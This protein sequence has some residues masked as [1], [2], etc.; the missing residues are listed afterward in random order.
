VVV[1]CGN[2]DTKTK[3][4]PIYINIYKHS[5]LQTEEAK[6]SAAVS[7]EVIFSALGPADSPT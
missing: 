7:T 3:K 5:R 6:A 1:T 4:V 2:A